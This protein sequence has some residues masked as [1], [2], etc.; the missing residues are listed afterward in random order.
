MLIGT[1]YRLLHIAYCIDH[2]LEPVRLKRRLVVGALHVA[3]EREMLLNHLCAHSHSSDR[4][5]NAASVVTVA[6]FHAKPLG[7]CVHGSKIHI[8]ERRGIL[9]VAV[10]QCDLVAAKPATLKHI[11]GSC[12]FIE[13]A[14]SRGHNHRAMLRCDFAQIREIGDFARRHFVEV[15]RKRFEGVDRHEVEGSAHKAYSHLIAHRLEAHIVAQ[16]QVNSAA[17]VELTLVAA[18]GFLLILGFRGKSGDYE[19]GHG[20]LELHI[21][22]S[23][24]LSLV[25]H[26]HGEV[27]VS[28]VVHTRLGNY[29]HMIIH[30]KIFTYL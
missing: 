4:H 17:H 28:I 29:H 19:F 5:L 18:G 1:A 21:V 10:Q 26:L 12:N 25:Y 6:H 15:H 13:I 27:V 2:R 22:G 23:G 11:D 30:C 9:G 8:A 3:V 16:R 14:H 7:Y 24:T 20:S